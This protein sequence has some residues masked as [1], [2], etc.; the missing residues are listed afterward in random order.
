LVTP[1]PF[2]AIPP[3]LT[4]NTMKELTME[5]YEATHGGIWL[6]LAAGLILAAGATIINEWDSFKA[7]L[8]GM[9]DPAKPNPKLP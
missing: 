9:R 3:G 6:E 2:P 8:M 7:G 4:N 1:E 5:E